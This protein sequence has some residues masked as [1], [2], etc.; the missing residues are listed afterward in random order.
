MPT[1]GWVLEGD[2]ERFLTG[3]TQ[4]DGIRTT[5]VPR[6]ACPFCHAGFEQPND[7]S[8]HLA[9]AHVGQRPFIHLA[10]AE[11]GRHETIRQTYSPA[12]IKLFN[13]TDVH[14]SF[15]GQYFFDSDKKTIEGHFAKARGR[16]WLSLEN[17]F[18][19]AAEPIRTD[20]DIRF[21]APGLEHLANV[22]RAFVQ[23]LGRSDPTVADVD[24]FI[25]S[26]PPGA[27]TEYVDA[28]ANY[29]LGI[30]IKDGD[31][32]SGVR[33]TRDCRPKLNGA[34][35]AFQAFDRPLPNLLATVIR[36]CENDF[37]RWWE[38]SGVA[39]LD[40]VNRWLGP[41]TA[42]SGSVYAAFDAECAGTE[43]PVCPIDNGS[44]TVIFRAEQLLGVVRWGESLSSQ[45][46]HDVES[47]D[48]DRLDQLKVAALWASRAIALGKPEHAFEPLG[49]LE[50]DHCF[51][52]WAEAAL[53]ELNG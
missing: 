3:T 23:I 32:A 9:Q 11:P 49:M 24:Q 28:M 5:H 33:G 16:M 30:L 7:L 29:V 18:D 41:L 21:R 37:S 27:V 40:A 50:G 44:D 48:W 51:G 13:C 38:P 35:R 17:R 45:L 4:I 6:H 43:T 26:C 2:I 46:R 10:G 8:D 31:P 34:L 39:R 22:E 36:F 19:K 14:L 52:R 25:A 47:N 20:Y 15:D 53:E 42:K 12:A 1:L